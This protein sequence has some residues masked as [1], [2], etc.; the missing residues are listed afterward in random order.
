MLTRAEKVELVLIHG[1]NRTN[2]ET[3]QIFNERHPQK[4]VSHATVGK[5]LKKFKN[6]GSVENNF[7][8]EH[9]KWEIVRNEE[10]VLLD[11]IENKKTSVSE[12]ANRTSSS[13]STVRRI[14]KKHK[15]YPYKPKFINTLRETDFDA[16]LEF[17]A[18]FQG[19]IEDNRQ[20]PFQ[21]LFSDEATF[22]SN[23]VVSSQNCRWWSDENPNFTIECKNQYSFK[24][25]VWCGILNNR[26][27]GPFFFHGNLNADTYLQFLRQDISDFI[28]DMPLQERCSVWYQQ[29]GAA[30]HSTI[31]VRNYLNDLF[32]G[33]WIG[34]F[35]QYPWPARSPDLTPLDFFLWGH[36]KNEV[37]KRRPFIN[38][39]DL[40]HKIRI[41]CLAISPSTIRKALQ[42]FSRRTIKCIEREGRLVEM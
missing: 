42:E 34:R 16:R 7:K 1:E 29:D 36:L 15:Y 9:I 26:I 11:V 40:E 35:S 25:N 2:R 17:C 28:D 32:H 3:S 37:Y 24:T 14:L 12:I 10:N 22:S 19:E 5:I 6:T 31:E 18:W 39:Q 41:C 30:I 20:F 23:G 38:I 27:I 4:R 21:I 8:K 13:Q 33:R